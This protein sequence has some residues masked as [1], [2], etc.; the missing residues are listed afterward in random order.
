[1]ISD[2][3]LMIEDWNLQTI[4]PAHFTTISNVNDGGIKF[5]RSR[6]QWKNI[7]SD[8]TC[9]NNDKALD[10]NWKYLMVIQYFSHNHVIWSFNLI[11]SGSALFCDGDHN[12]CVPS[13]VKSSPYQRAAE[14][15]DIVPGYREFRINHSFYHDG[16]NYRSLIGLKITFVSHAFFVFV[17]FLLPPNNT[18]YHLKLPLINAFICNFDLPVIYYF[19][20]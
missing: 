20:K 13:C 1:M 6:G 2:F 12:C 18:R 19:I 14:V 5:E 15:I 17:P 3:I 16:N 8:I 10:M 11:A 9:R 4:F 7:L